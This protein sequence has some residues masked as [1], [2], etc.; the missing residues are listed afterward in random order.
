MVFKTGQ[1]S[2]LNAKDFLVF[3]VVDINSLD[4]DEI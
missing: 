1:R 3:K 2:D 4:N